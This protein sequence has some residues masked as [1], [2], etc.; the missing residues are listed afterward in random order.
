MKKKHEHERAFILYS[1]SVKG[2][3]IEVCECGAR[4]LIPKNPN[5]KTMWT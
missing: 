2:L 3:K 5:H 1:P 4:R